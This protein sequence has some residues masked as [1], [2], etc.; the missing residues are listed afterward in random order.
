MFEHLFKNSATC[1]RHREAPFSADREGYL[2]WLTQRGYSKHA[3][4]MAAARLLVVVRGLGT[5]VVLG[6]ATPAQIATAA[7][8]WERQRRRSRRL[9]SH[10]TSGFFVQIA[11]DWF[12]FLGRLREPITQPLPY[13]QQLEEFSRWMREER[14]LASETMR[15]KLFHVGE[16]LR[17]HCARGGTIEGLRLPHIDAFLA[18]RGSARWCRRTM[19][20]SADSLRAFFRYG[21]MRGWWCPSI[22]EAIEGPV[23]YRDENMPAGPSW[24]DVGRLLASLRPDDPTDVRDRAMIMLLSVYGLRAG[25]VARMSLDDI[26]WEQR[27]LMVRRSKSG[28]RQRYPLVA[29]VARALWAYLHLRPTCSPSE[30]FVT[31]KAPFKHVSR[32]VIYNGVALRLAALGVRLRHQGPHSLRHACAARLI[33]Q[34][35][36][37][38]EIGDHLGH[39]SPAA[40]RIYA[41]VDLPHLQEV[42]AFDLGGLS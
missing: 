28:T 18:E 7:A 11:T 26:K 40:T 25:E 2:Q 24:D 37:L 39:R 30:V 14:N 5:R 3:V 13:A 32:H 15:T 27:E 42:A 35:L 19:A 10:W 33:S 8:K 12:R 31:M 41:K 36:S 4:Q 1:R 21:A 9:A 29:S 20:S 34:G 23:V 6:G 22:A 17:W 16:L 38:K